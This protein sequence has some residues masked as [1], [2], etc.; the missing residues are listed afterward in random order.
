MGTSQG[1]FRAQMRLNGIAPD[2]NSLK[3][4]YYMAAL[5]KE[6]KIK[7][8]QTTALVVASLGAKPSAAI[9]ALNDFLEELFPSLSEAREAFFEMGREIL[10]KEAGKVIDLS[11][12]H[13]I[14]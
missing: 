7:A 13:R 14:D 2:Y 11:N 9:D 12:Y 5:A 4:A 1:W 10:E 3:E 8:K 6:Q